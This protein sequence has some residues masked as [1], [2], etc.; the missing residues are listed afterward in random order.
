MG[1]SR[2]SYS[3]QNGQLKPAYHVQIAVSSE[4][5]TEVDVLSNQTDFGTLIP[6]LK[7]LQYHHKA[8]YAEAVPDAGTEHLDRTILPSHGV[9]PEKVVDETRTRTLEKSSFQNADRLASRKQNTFSRCTAFGAGLGLLFSKS[10]KIQ[11]FSTYLMVPLSSEAKKVRRRILQ[12]CDDP[13]F[14]YTNQGS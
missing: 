10:R 1:E 4:Y 12:F 3:M 2:N 14:S 11:K 13:I 6:S 8:R 5:I 7:Q 9:S